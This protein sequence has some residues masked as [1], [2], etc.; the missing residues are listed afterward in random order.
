MI[1]QIIEALK[2]LDKAEQ[3]YELLQGKYKIPRTVKEGIK[4]VKL[5]GR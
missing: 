1:E 2:R 5:F 3:G 4:Q